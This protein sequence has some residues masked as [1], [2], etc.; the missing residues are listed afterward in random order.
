MDL[1]RFTTA[2]SVDDGKST[3]I[4]R[5][6]HDTG[7]IK[8]DTALSVITDDKG[9]N[10]AYITDGLRL[11]REGG[12]TI[13]IGYKYFHTDKRKFIISDAPG[14]F[15]YTKNL[16]TG[17]SNVD[18][19]T[20]LIDAVNGITAQTKR[21]LLAAWFLKVPHVAI[22]VNKMDVVGYSED[23]FNSIKTDMVNYCKTL[24]LP[25]PAFIPVSALKGDNVSIAGQN[26][27][28]YT[29]E[30]L[31][32]YLENVTPVA[33]MTDINEGVRFA[34][35]Y[36]M[37]E[38]DACYYYGKLISGAINN[39]VSLIDVKKSKNLQLKRIFVDMNEV[40]QA[41]TGDNICLELGGDNI[42]KRGDVLTTVAD[43]MIISNR[44]KVIICWLD[45]TQ[46]LDMNHKYLLRINGQEEYCMLH[47]LEWK[48]DSG[49][50]KK[51]RGVSSLSV[52]EFG[53]AVI[54]TEAVIAYD[55][56]ERIKETGRGVL[57]DIE[58]NKTIA[59]FTIV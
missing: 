16:V 54:E 5:L 10:L 29:G 32:G 48:K 28:W 49:D 22:A 38:D 42:F 58:S 57:I 13:D 34:I 8:E 46:G 55:S 26:M 41:N 7:N 11:E 47:Q 45:E 3:L 24:G 27:P 37:H 6:L 21:H 43:D 52:N 25:M 31:L 40:Q 14:H 53:C 51:I 19:M 39:K 33:F 35:Q 1:L 50:F 2:G 23:G 20:I 9:L 18:V 4:G 30:T 15:Q 17:A 59:A 36:V 56:Y 44:L 12:I